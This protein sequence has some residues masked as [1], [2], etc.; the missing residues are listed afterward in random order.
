MLEETR[1][2]LRR[3]RDLNKVERKVGK[4]EAI[5]G[6]DWVAGMLKR[7]ET[8]MEVSNRYSSEHKFF[9]GCSWNWIFLYEDFLTF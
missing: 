5:G 9:A 7:W 6:D 8:K 3:F 1:R 4:G 2:A